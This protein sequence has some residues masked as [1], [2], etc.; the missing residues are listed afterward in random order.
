MPT[1][2]VHCIHPIT[3]NV[4][5]GFARIPMLSRPRNGDTADV[6][7]DSTTMETIRAVLVV[8]D[9]HLYYKQR[10]WETRPSR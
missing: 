3:G 10:S 1:Y 5:E 2:T 4:I 9:Q 7:I 6:T 8:D